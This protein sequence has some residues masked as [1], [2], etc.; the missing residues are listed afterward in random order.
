MRRGRREGRRMI[1]R[2]ARGI[3]APLCAASL[4][5]C[6]FAAFLWFHGRQVYRDSADVTIGRTYIWATSDRY[7]VSVWIIGGWPW[8]QPLR[9]RSAADLDQ[10]EFFGLEISP[11]WHWSIGNSGAFITGRVWAFVGPD[12]TPPRLSKHWNPIFELRRSA[13]M[14]AWMMLNGPH[15]AIVLLTSLAPLTWLTLRQR[16]RMALRRR[17]RLGL[18]LRCGYDL[19]ASR[20]S[21]RCSECG[22]AIRP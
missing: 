14:P 1:G 19:R 13:R 18:C 9:V 12:G 10:I 6:L 21:G 17:V 22:E 16:R 3:V 4:L 20:D 8:P 11:G 7:G 2:L 15:W 5:A